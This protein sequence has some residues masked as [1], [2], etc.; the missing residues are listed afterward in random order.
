M[1]GRTHYF[2]DL[3]SD[4]GFSDGHNLLRSPHGKQM[5]AVEPFKF[6]EFEEFEEPLP[7]RRRARPGDL[8]A[9][10]LC[11]AKTTQFRTKLR[12]RI[13]FLI[14]FYLCL[15]GLVDVLG[16]ISQNHFPDDMDLIL[17]QWIS[18]PAATIGIGHWIFDATRY[19]HPVGCHSH[20][21][22]WRTVPLIDAIAAGCPSVEADVWHQ[23]GDLYVGHREF[24]LR[25]NRT[26]RSLY[27]DP[28]INIIERQNNLPPCDPGKPCGSR[29]LTDERFAGVFS[30]EPDQ[31][32]VL[33]IDFKT[34]GE[35]MWRELQTQ[36][37][38]L[39]DRN[40]LTYFNGTA[41]I[42][43][44]VIVVGTGK[45]PF[46]D[47]AASNT[48]REVFFDAPL[49]LLADMS[50]KW[51]N[52]NRAEDGARATDVESIDGASHRRDSGTQS[53]HAIDTERLHGY[54]SSNS[55]YASANFKHAVGHVFGSRLTQGQLQLIRAQV[56][57]AHRLGLKARYWGVPAWPIGLRNHIWHILI[58]EGVDVLSV[59]DL[60]QATTWDWRRKKGL[61]F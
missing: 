7:W 12:N 58:R 19:V 21:D 4:A 53:V 32:L 22:Y 31:P 39:R 28:L 25:A 13:C 11:H 57:G 46:D 38:A 52:P 14:V 17:H 61:L 29:W 37:K 30:A 49:E 48:Y 40:M 42:P 50:A 1:A 27:I 34:P 20:N 2:S 9:W 55:Y 16:N 26:L 35:S 5:D 54:D 33:V 45:A 18:A 41:I 44:P 47:M 8:L 36:L 3:E 59:D 10:V 60:R 15:V 24:E 23:D 6:E 56:R 43:G 51:P